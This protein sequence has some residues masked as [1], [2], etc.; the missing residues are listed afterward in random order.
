MSENRE[1][2]NPIVELASRLRAR[3]DLGS[4]IDSALSTAPASAEGTSGDV[5]QAL[6]AFGEALRLGSVRLNAI[7]GNKNGVTY[8]R[9]ER[10]FRLRL[11]FGD[12]RVTLDADETQ[13]LV[14]VSGLGLDGEYQFDAGAA[15]PSL[16]NLSRLSTEEG[17]GEA[18][19]PASLLRLIAEDAELPRPA[20][21][22]SPGPLSF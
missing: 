4:A 11:R 22:D 16:I 20:H 9:L 18:L 1:P 6:G 8:V 7:L 5:L 17:Y 21:L 10:P 12:K 15:T 14:R 13:Q 2:Q 3:H 19:T